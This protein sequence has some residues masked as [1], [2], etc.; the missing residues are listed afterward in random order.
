VYLAHA[1]IQMRAEK[2]V[3]TRKKDRKKAK[4]GESIFYNA[5]RKTRRKKCALK[6][7]E[8]AI[9]FPIVQA[10]YIYSEKKLYTLRRQG[11][12]FRGE[13]C[14]GRCK[15]SLRRHSSDKLVG[16]YFVVA[17]TRAEQLGKNNLTLLNIVQRNYCETVF[18]GFIV[19]S[20]KNQRKKN[21]AWI[22]K[23]N[24]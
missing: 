13:L 22:K 5:L 8:V 16:L 24:L 10:Y 3:Q 4:R 6:S 1:T 9:V 2:G 14:D 19:F 23:F 15:S 20:W 18:N 21:A 17:F 7:T 12:K 11:W